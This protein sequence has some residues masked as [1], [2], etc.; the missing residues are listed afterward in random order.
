VIQQAQATSYSTDE[1]A[2]L[3]REA[4]TASSAV[5]SGQMAEV[6]GAAVAPGLQRQPLP[7]AQPPSLT[8]LPTYSLTLDNFSTDKFELSSDHKN[9]LD[10]FAKRL[11]TSLSR[12]P[13]TV[14]TV[15]GFADAPGTEPHNLALG[16]QRADAVRGYLV[17][18]GLPANALPAFSLGEQV[19]VIET[20]GHEARNRRVDIDVVER[21]FFRPSLA[22]TPPTTL[23]TPSAAQPKLDLKVHPETHQPTPSEEFQDKLRQID[24]AV[25]EAEKARPGTSVAGLFGRVAREAAKKLGLPKWVQDRAESLAR[26][27]PSKGAQAV[28]DQIAGDQNLDPSTKNAVRAVIDALMRTEIK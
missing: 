13:D 20:K 27:V 8:L 14:I 9:K 6:G 5:M 24:K 28:F 23:Q 22:L 16:Q 2:V 26:D 25:R 18:K 7:G 10:D 11:K 15:V 12:S 1:D 19:P 4:L 21:N 3:E 17:E